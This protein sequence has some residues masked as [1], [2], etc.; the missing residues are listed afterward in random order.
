MLRNT[1]YP[2]V[3]DLGGKVASLAFYVVMARK[4]GA[5]DFG[6]FTFALAFGALI[7]TVADFEQDK[8]LTREVARDPS[9]STATSRTRSR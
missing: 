7:T 1:L 8:I 6:V 4:L 3:G 2:L 5:A 9:G